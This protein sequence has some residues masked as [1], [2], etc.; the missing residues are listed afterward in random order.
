MSQEP[1][2]TLLRAQER[3]REAVVVLLE[4]CADL[5]ALPSSLDRAL[6]ILET[7][8]VLVESVE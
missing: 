3:T 1:S 8:R 7:Q 5:T 6:K 2:W 4:G